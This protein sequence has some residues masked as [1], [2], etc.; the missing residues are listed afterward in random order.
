MEKYFI[1]HGN[2]NIPNA[3][4]VKHCIYNMHNKVFFFFFF[5]RAVNVSFLFCNFLIDLLAVLHMVKEGNPK[6]IVEQYL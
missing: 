6:W 4:H 3:Y 2:V 5:S 1:T